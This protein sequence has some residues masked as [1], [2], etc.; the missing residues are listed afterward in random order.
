NMVVGAAI[1]RSVFVVRY[2]PQPWQGLVLRGLLV[3]V[4]LIRGQDCRCR[5][6]DSQLVPAS[7]TLT[8]CNHDLRLKL[9]ERTPRVE[10][11]TAKIAVRTMALALGYIT[12]NRNR[13]AAHLGRQTVEFVLREFRRSAIYHKRQINRLLPN[14]QI[15]I[16]EVGRHVPPP[17]AD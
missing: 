14:A 1:R 3:S 7:D 17:S 8:P 2:S 16:R 9:K 4:H 12:R 11:E 13:G 5:A 6:L 10:E 15:S